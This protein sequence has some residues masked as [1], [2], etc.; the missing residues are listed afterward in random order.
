MKRNFALNATL[1]ALIPPK[2][3]V[4]RRLAPPLLHSPYVLNEI[5]CIFPGALEVGPFIN[6][7]H[8][9]QID[10]VGRQNLEVFLGLRRIDQAQEKYVFSSFP[11]MPLTFN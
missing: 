11:R 2:P 4:G 10:F 9:A 7:D 5:F 6:W 1:F 8:P 3:F